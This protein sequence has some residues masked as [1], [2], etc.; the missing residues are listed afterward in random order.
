MDWGIRIGYVATVALAAGIPFF[1]VV[2]PVTASNPG[3]GMLI[4]VM[5]VWSAVLTFLADSLMAAVAAGLRG[6]LWC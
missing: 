6:E 4:A 5:V 2:V 3:D 1:A